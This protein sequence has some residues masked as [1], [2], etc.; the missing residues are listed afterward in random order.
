MKIGKVG[1]VALCV[2]GI[3]YF[4]NLRRIKMRCIKWF[5]YV[6]VLFLAGKPRKETPLPG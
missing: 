1:S 2:G 3:K 4:Y 5:G 6:C